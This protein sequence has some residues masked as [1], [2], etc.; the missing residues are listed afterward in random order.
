MCA[1][2]LSAHNP[3]KSK[4]R[5]D[6][7]ANTILIH[8]SPPRRPSTTHYVRT[9]LRLSL[10]FHISYVHLP[11]STESRCFQNKTDST[12][13]PTLSRLPRSFSALLS[14]SADLLFQYLR[15]PTRRFRRPTKGVFWEGTLDSNI[16]SLALVSLAIGG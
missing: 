11:P 15:L 1:T 10:C 14:L 13:L 7:V 9:P 12:C 4:E 16:Q 5:Q 2:H 6:L 3:S 8:S